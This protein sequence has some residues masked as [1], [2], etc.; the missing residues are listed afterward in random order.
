MLHPVSPAQTHAWADFLG[1]AVRNGID[2][3]LVTQWLTILADATGSPLLPSLASMP[4]TE[5]VN[6]RLP[7]ILAGLETTTHVP[8]LAGW[9]HRIEPDLGHLPVRLVTTGAIAG[10]IY[11]WI[12][13]GCSR[14]TIKNTLAML[15]RILEQAVVDGLIE[16]APAHVTGWQS[17]YQQAE[18]E[19]LDPRA[20]ALRDWDALTE[21]AD[22]LIDASYN[23]Y[24]GWGDVIVHGACTATRIGEVSGVRACDIDT[25]NWLLTCRRQTTPAPGGL[26]DKHTKGKIAR[27]IPII[28]PL[29]PLIT[30]RLEATHGNPDARLYTGPRG[31]R[32]S[33]AVLRD[34]THWNDVTQDLGYEHL[35]RHD[36]RHT[37]LTWM[38]DAGILPHILQ[39]I[40][41]HKEFSTTRRYF[42]P[43]I[44]ELT[45]AG[46]AFTRHLV[47]QLRITGRIPHRW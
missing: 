10:A 19:L 39:E 15:F 21:L 13:E 7:A 42:H 16:R 30:R 34:A 28:E 44:R 31:G 22:A 3:A 1:K 2:P 47:E 41:G 40:A 17:A 23:H 26:V 24:R 20:L 18:D 33:T 32:I 5:Y 29:R 8:Y 4:L 27:F 9:H 11:S 38:A 45:K 14:S 6:R 36:L 12:A 35:R 46:E 25:R 37:G 43:D